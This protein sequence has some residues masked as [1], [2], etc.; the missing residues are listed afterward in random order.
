MVKDLNNYYSKLNKDINSFY[1][2]DDH[3]KYIILNHLYWIENDITREEISKTFR[4][5]KDADVFSGVSMHQIQ[6]S[7]GYKI[8][9]KEVI[10]KFDYEK[11]K[12]LWLHLSSKSINLSFVKYCS[13]LEEINIG[14][15]EEINLDALKYNTK[16]K[17]I[18]ANDNNI[19]NIE[20]LY[21]HEY[22][23]FINIENN[24]CCSLKPIAHLKKIKKIEV[25]LI[26]DEMDI[27]NVLK[28]NTVCKV[29]Y[30]IR[31]GETGFE[32][33]IIPYYLLS[34]TKDESQIEFF[35]GRC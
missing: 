30:I 24:S 10:S 33:L 27:L 1:S 23:E 25:G 29:K 34:I 35:F 18:I 11:I 4:E 2:M 13:N 32:N 17:S 31:G 19:S 8:N 12:Y 7:M 26:D 9:D 16:L 20:V 14:C 28:N 5:I 6:E 22:L 3:T 21:S 15:Y